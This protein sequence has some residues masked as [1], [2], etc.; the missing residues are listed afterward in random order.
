M[1]TS[2]KMQRT[3]DKQAKEIKEMKSKLATYK[4]IEEE[5][6][7]SV[8]KEGAYLELMRKNELLK[9]IIIN[10]K[11]VLLDFGYTNKELSKLLK[12]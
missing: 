8:L 12:K 9:D 4:G 11:Q 3:L 7:E 6:E 2:L 1:K 10:S 5:Q